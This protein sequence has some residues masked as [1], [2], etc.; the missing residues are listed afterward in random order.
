MID[1][2]RDAVKYLDDTDNGTDDGL[3]YDIRLDMDKGV[4]C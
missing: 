3:F 4:R 1:I 2:L